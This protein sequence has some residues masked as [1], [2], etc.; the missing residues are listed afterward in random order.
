MPQFTSLSS[1][2]KTGTIKLMVTRPFCHVTLVHAA[3]MELAILQFCITTKIGPFDS[4][5][6]GT[7]PKNSS[8]L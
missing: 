5:L 8:A 4:K 2:H 6:Q 3:G 1:R 7:P